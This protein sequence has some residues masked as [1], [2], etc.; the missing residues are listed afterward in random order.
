MMFYNVS[1]NVNKRLRGLHDSKMM[2]YYNLF[3]GLKFEIYVH[4]LIFSWS[5]NK[6]RLQNVII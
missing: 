4:Y 3:Y 1:V 6:T 5:L 2:H